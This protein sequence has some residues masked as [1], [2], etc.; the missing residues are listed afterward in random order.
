M[1]IRTEIPHEIRLTQ[2]SIG[3]MP[4][5]K[6]AVVEVEVIVSPAVFALG[7]II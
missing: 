7:F 3:L 1:H 4:K 6:S 2:P 5:R